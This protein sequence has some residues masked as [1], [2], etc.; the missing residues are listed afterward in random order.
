MQLFKG[1]DPRRAHHDDRKREQARN[2]IRTS[3]QQA[4]EEFIADLRRQDPKWQTP[5]LSAEKLSAQI[6][7]IIELGLHSS[8]DLIR[9]TLES[10]REEL[11]SYDMDAVRIAM[12]LVEP[13]ATWC[14]RPVPALVAIRRNVGFS[15]S[16]CD[17]LQG[18]WEEHYAIYRAM[19]A[20]VR[21]DLLTEG[22]P[23][24]PG[25]QE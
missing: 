13:F 12:P 2:L 14:E 9:A 15:R 18:V 22:P 23:S 8:T 6:C 3:V 10:Q 24:L 20:R 17:E 16:D 5:E 21:A 11:L 25:P 4:V 7:A 19:L 1:G